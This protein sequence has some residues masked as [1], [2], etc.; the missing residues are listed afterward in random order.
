M[1]SPVRAIVVG[2]V[3]L[4]ATT[5]CSTAPLGWWPLSRQSEAERPVRPGWSLSRQSEAGR[6]V[7]R[8]EILV[9]NGD[10][11]TARDLYERVIRKHAD[12]PASTEA[13]YRLGVLQADPASGLRD[14][15]AARATFTQLLTERPRSRW[16][17]E[18]RAWQATLTDLLVR[19]DEAR[20]A[21]LRLK[22]FEEESK[23]VK[24]NLERLRQTDLELERRR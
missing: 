17:T 15:R 18:A 14:Y 16:E 21:T 11:A 9:L 19:E 24:S 1:K 4:I 5:G 12:D 22:G 10:G 2:V 6:A 23:R 3:L 20:R 13:L 7:R 8:A